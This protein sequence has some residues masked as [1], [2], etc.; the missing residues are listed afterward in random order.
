[1]AGGDISDILLNSSESLVKK[2]REEKLKTQTLIELKNSLDNE[3]L[4][5]PLV[6]A[7]YVNSNNVLMIICVLTV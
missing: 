4:L 6:M 3:L 1:M 2:F 5:D 7:K